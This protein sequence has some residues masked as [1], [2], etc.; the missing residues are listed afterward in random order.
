MKN[1]FK[2]LVLLLAI[3]LVSCDKPL[4]EVNIDPNT[5][6]TAND[7]QVLTAAQGYLGY[8]VDVDLNSRSFL[9]AQYYTWGIGVSI[10][11]AERFVA[12]PDDYNGYW[13]RSYANCLED[14]K[15]LSESKSAAYRGVGK[16][17]QVYVFQSLVDHFGNIPYSDAL[18]GAIDDGSVLTPSFDADATIYGKL[19]EKIDDALVDLRAGSSADIGADDLVFGGNIANW[20]KFAN[21]LKLR[22]LMRTS[23]LGDNNASAIKDLIANG[24]F[25]ESASDI[26]QVAFDGKSGNQ[27]PMYARF[28]WGVGDFYFASNATLNV[29]NSLSDPRIGAFY[30]KASTGSFA[31]Q[32]R[33]IDQGTIDNEP[34][35]AAATEYSQSSPQAYAVDNSVILMSN[36]ETW[37]LRAEADARYG[38]ADDDAQAF[39]NAIEANF[40]YLGVAGGSAYATAQNYA[41]AANMDAK[42]DLIAVQK[43]ISMNGTQEDEGWIETRRFD[44]PASRLFTNG[45]F[46]TPPLSILGAGNFPASWLYPATEMS[47]NPKAPAQRSIIDKVFWDN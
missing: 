2:V 35:T 44:R 46:Q 42:I 1:I 10:G 40:D 9:W 43:W 28:T 6:P 17:L 7:A 21:S 4:D 16:A 20:I 26:A 32:F 23:E 11:N 47:L 37:F 31:G 34:F 19:A 22:I 18:N 24:S 15:Y 14:L 3:T 33:G 8:I 30:R 45:I 29:L 27:N 12:Q 39:A 5:S 38:T 41:S 13:Q 25:I 36:W